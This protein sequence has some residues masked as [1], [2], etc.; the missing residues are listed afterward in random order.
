MQ[1]P[2]PT[3]LRYRRDRRELTVAWAEARYTLEAEFLRVH[4]PSA[5]VQGHGGEGGSLPVDKADVALTAIEPVG[6]YAVRL[7]F[8]DGHA[9]GLY[10]WDWLHELCTRKEAL[11]REYRDKVARLPSAS[12]KAGIPSVRQYTT[13]K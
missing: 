10:S 13:G 2:A 6:N 9:S 11:W 12:A 8:S 4:S 3:E 7:V 5:E 1:T